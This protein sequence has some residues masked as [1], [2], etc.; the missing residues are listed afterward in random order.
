MVMQQNLSFVLLLEFGSIRNVTDELMCND[1]V[2]TRFIMLLKLYKE[3][4]E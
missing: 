1:A 4:K 3:K 2:M